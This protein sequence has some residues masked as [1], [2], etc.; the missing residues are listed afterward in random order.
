WL[1]LA[2]SLGILAVGGVIGKA[3]KQRYFPK[4]LS[5]LAFIDVFLPEDAPFGLTNET[6]TPGGAD[7]AGS[8]DGRETTPRVIDQLRG[9]RSTPFL[10]FAF[11][12]GAASQLR[13]DRLALQGQT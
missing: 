6:V 3:L 2:G 1:V 8:L 12:P 10:V 9:R 11:A 7:R 13:T 4:D 5:Q